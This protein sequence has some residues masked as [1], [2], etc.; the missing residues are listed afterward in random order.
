MSAYT[1]GP[2]TIHEAFDSPIYIEDGEFTNHTLDIM[3]KRKGERCFLAS[4]DFRTTPN[5]VDSLSE[6]R[7]NARLI[8]SAPELLEALKGIV[9]EMELAD[10]DPNDQDTW[11]GRAIALIQKAEAT[12]AH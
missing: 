5:K 1:K 7:A 12:D 8:A 2:W 11:Y 4:T 10:F 9:E 3:A 6:A